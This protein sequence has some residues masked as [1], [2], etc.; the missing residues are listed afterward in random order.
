MTY[1]TIQLLKSMMVALRNSSSKDYL[2]LQFCIDTI[3][4]LFENGEIEYTE[5]NKLLRTIDRI[6]YS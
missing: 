1:N 2:L 6:F 4:F 3:Y 5:R